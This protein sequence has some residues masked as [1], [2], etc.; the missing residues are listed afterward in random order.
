MPRT[1]KHD[2]PEQLAF[3]LLLTVLVIILLST[4]GLLVAAADPAKPVS[5][6]DIL[7]WARSELPRVQAIGEYEA[8]LEAREIVAGKP[9]VTRSYIRVS[10]RPYRIFYRYL[11]PD[12]IAGREAL[13]TGGEFVKG[14]LGAGG[15]WFSL[16]INGPVAKRRTN[17]TINQ[18]G[19]A[20]VLEQLLREA[21]DK[22]AEL[23]ASVADAVVDN[24]PCKQY[25]FEHPTVLVRVVVDTELRV[26]VRIEVWTPRA[27]RF[28]LL[29]SFEYR[30]VHM[31]GN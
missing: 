31:T 29:E 27:G 2:D 21:Q 8:T 10:F 7:D 15:R 6:Q 20:A 25:T 14:R 24:R 18:L 1:R 3:L 4:V 5:A 30:D 19:F 11:A 17:H 22:G 12:D 16:P 28:E 9:V 13:Y 26:P 23:T